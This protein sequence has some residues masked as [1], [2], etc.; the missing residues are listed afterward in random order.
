LMDGDVNVES[1][2]GK[3]TTIFVRIPVP[4][5]KGPKPHG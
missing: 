1:S 4:V 2:P 3:G 5:F